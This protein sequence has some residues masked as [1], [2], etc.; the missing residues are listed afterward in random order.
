MTTTGFK[1]L[2]S[3][4]YWKPGFFWSVQRLKLCWHRPN[5]ILGRGGVLVSL[6]HAPAFQ[7]GVLRKEES[8]YDLGAQNRMTMTGPFFFPHE[9][10]LCS[11]VWPR[12]HCIVQVGFK[13]MIILTRGPRVLGLQTSIHISSVRPTFNSQEQMESSF[14]NLREKKS[15]PAANKPQ[16]GHCPIPPRKRQVA[17]H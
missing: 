8:D 13:L 5:A 6:P 12:I 16:N 17:C 3:K 15:I 2:N 1:V 14:Y 4:R 11:P 10:S 9:V 7:R